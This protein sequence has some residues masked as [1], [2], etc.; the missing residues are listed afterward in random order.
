MDLRALVSCEPDIAHLSRLFCF[1]H[2]FK[3]A[4]TCE[5]AV[6]IGLS[7]YFVKLQKINMIGLQPLQRLV[8][9]LTCRE[10]V[11][12][13]DLGHQKCLLAIAIP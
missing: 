10:F 5:Y 9:L 12:A 1:H 7:N 2:R 3:S 4:T 13:I 8:E 11:P 6:G